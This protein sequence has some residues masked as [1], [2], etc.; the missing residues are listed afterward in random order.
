MSKINCNI[1][2]VMA[3]MLFFDVYSFDI[4]HVSI[5]APIAANITITIT[6]KYIRISVIQNPIK[7]Q[8]IIIVIF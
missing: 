7:F 1:V 6:I 4:E 5:I 3:D 8:A 2:I